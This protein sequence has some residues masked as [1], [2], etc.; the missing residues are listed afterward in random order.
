MRNTV[1]YLTAEPLTIGFCEE[2][3]AQ[4]YGLDYFRQ[5]PTGEWFTSFVED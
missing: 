2:M 3:K 5:L 1:N 4:G